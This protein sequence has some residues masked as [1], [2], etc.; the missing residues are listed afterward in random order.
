MRQIAS[1]L[2]AMN[3]MLA[4]VIKDHILTHLVD[5]DKALDSR[6]PDAAD[7]LVDIVR[8]YFK[9]NTI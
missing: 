9:R 4:A 3:G 8:S 2:G 1:A 6:E 5:P 7:Q